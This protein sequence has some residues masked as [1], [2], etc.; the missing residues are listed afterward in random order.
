[1]IWSF[2]FFVL[3]TLVGVFAIIGFVVGRVSGWTAI[4]RQYRRDD[5]PPGQVLRFR[6]GRFG[7]IDYSACLTIRI[8]PEGLA[9]AMSP[10]LRAGHPPLFLPWSALAIE[11][12]HEEWWNRFL[13]V[14]LQGD[15]GWNLRLPLA[16]LKE[17]EQARSLANS[18]ERRQDGETFAPGGGLDAGFL[19]T[20]GGVGR[21]KNHESNESDESGEDVSSVQPLADDP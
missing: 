12:V 4:A 15:P 6:S 8:C 20:D 17:A 19:T 1:M 9:L 16:I 11:S 5:P 14:H 7:A 18:A 10:I 3:V 13:A 2:A 21:R